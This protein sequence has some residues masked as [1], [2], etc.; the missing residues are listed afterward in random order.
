MEVMIVIP[1]Y[2]PDER[3]V[4]YVEDLIKSGFN[5]VLIVDDGSKNE[6][7]QIIDG[8]VQK[9]NVLMIR[10]ATNMGKGR[11]IKNALN[12]CAVNYPCAGV[13]T[14]DSDGQ[15]TVKDV[16]K[17]KNALE[18]NPCSLILGCR[19]FDS[20]NVPYKSAFGN[21]ATRNVM[22]L[23]HGGNISDTQTGLRGFSPNIICEY[24]T[25]PGER[26]EYET[27]VL[28]ETLRK[29]IP[30]FEVKIDT[31]Y[32]DNNSETHFRPFV[33]SY[34]IYCVIL[35]SFI[36]F[37]F[38]SVFCSVLDIFVFFILTQIFKNFQLASKVWIS[39]ALA[40]VISSVANYLINRNIVFKSIG[41]KSLLKY[42]SLAAI[43]MSASAFFVYLF[44]TL[45]GFPEVIIKMI[46]DTIL[47][48][49]SYRVQK[50]YVF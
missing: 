48:F 21:K 38:S 25:I 22:R 19:D 33:D 20:D 31:V 43:Q 18:E 12:F 42:Y 45:I 13:I 49:I 50:R 35:K 32:F 30:I 5:N 1:A 24:L 40:R 28:I 37:A 7:V 14:V 39:T 15:H 36:S 17:V 23:L 29:K 44:C 6:C 2:N 3:L 47:F 41:N 11:A 8:V 27:A 4:A 26:F 16:I 34:K 9:F 46:V 10:H